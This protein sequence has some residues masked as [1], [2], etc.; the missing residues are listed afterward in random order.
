METPSRIFRQLIRTNS[1]KR[2]PLLATSSLPAA[3][4]DSSHLMA[5][6]S[7]K[8][9][10]KTAPAY[11]HNYTE[12]SRR[13]PFKP[14]LAQNARIPA[15]NPA[16]LIYCYTKPR[17]CQS[18]VRSLSKMSPRATARFP[19]SPR[20]QTPLLP[21]PVGTLRERLVVCPV[22]TF[23]PCA[24]PQ[25]CTLGAREGQ[26]PERGVARNIGPTFPGRAPL[27]QA[28]DGQEGGR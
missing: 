3:V 18:S 27:V 21:L 23:A 9:G 1:L 10:W 5:L 13:F 17:K 20:Q 11:P 25:R 16:R 12:I 14:F 28:G 6:S 7:T 2:Y 26:P 24:Y 22:G 15:K 19:P 4:E 8:L